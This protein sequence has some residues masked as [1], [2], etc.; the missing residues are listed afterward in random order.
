MAEAI[1]P[2]TYITVRDEGLISAGSVA[3]GNIGIVGT[4]SKGPVDTVKIIG[5][6]SEAQEIFGESDSW[7]GGNKN[8]LTLMRALE[9]VYNNGGRTVYAV[10]TAASKTLT[11]ASYQLKDDSNADLLKLEACTPG[12]WGKDIKIKIS[13]AEANQKKVELSYGAIQE[14]YVVESAAALVEAIKNTRKS[15]LVT[16]TDPAK[17]KSTALPKNTDKDEGDSFSPGANG[18]DAG[19]EDYQKSLALLENEIVNVVLLAG[20]DTSVSWIQEVLEGHLKTTAEIKRERIGIIG[21]GFKE[22]KDNL[23]EISKHTF[24]NERVIFT[25]PGIL[26]SARGKQEKDPLPGGYL[27]A[28]V[29]G[30]IASLPVQASPTNKTLTIGGLSTEFNASQLEKL[31]LNRVLAVEKRDG[32]RVVKG[33]TTNDGAWKQI[34]TRRI[35]DYA[36]YGVR[37]SCNPY[38]GKLNNDRVRSAMKATLNAFLTRMVNDEALVGY[39]LAVSATRA[40]EIAGEA[41][42]T[43]TLKPT[44][45]IDFIRVTMYLG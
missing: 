15:V 25:A 10:R 22:G 27:A 36:I 19:K 38:I 44:F 40:Q 17:N 43:L 3:S 34:T 16:A 11:K 1:L 32:F 31:V 39:E 18:A 33:I 8:E 12:T 35:V 29:A 28:A 14:A 41:I 4:A 45:S 23:D 9:Q 20:Q 7:Q 42:V 26:V 13:D 30:L 24:N 6:F 2:G 5:S 21:S 37:S